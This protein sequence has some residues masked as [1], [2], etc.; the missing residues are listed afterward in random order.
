MEWEKTRNIG[1]KIP[2]HN[3]D[4]LGYF[5][6]ERAGNFAVSEN[7]LF[8]SKKIPSDA[9]SFLKTTVIGK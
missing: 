1:D 6:A 8:Y 3:E 4:V 9:T 7:R 5:F 2:M